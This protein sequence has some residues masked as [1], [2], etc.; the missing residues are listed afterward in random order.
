MEGNPLTLIPV[1]VFLLVT[2]AVVMRINRR[3]AV[4]GKS[5]VPEYFIGSRSLGGFVLAMTTIATYGS[6]SSFVG[7]PGQAWSVGWGWVYMS[8]V[9][10]T[11]LFLLFGILGKKLALISRKIGAITIID[12]LR[13]RYKSDAIANIS[14]VIILLFFAAMMVAQFVGGAKL[15]ESV[16][17]YSYVIGLLI[18]GIV[19]ISYT[20]VGGFR[21]VAVTDAICGVMM[22]VGIVILAAGILVAGGGYENIMNTIMA[23]NPGM[24]DPLSDGQMPIGLYVTQWLL[25]GVL[26]FCLPQSVVRC[27]G[28]KDEK[29]LKNAM[30]VGTVIIGLMMICVTSLGVLSKG[31]LPG[32][33]R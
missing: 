30:V 13:A 22:I 21:G 20:T 25:V 7:G 17:G 12:V 24:M 26:T 31:V 28:F 32:L 14:A 6:V 23:E 16:T 8:A 10:V 18:F 5:F 4:E 9:Q 1:L 19:V 33:A 29:A 3:V 11:A 27:M 15:F 2:F